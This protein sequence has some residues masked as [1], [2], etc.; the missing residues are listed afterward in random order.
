[1]LKILTLILCEPLYFKKLAT[2][3]SF[4][5]IYIK[6]SKI[7]IIYTRKF[8][9]FEPRSSLTREDMCVVNDLWMIQSPDWI[10]SKPRDEESF[11][12]R[13]VVSTKIVVTELREEVHR[14]NIHDETED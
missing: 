11:G 10:N 2:D 4:R 5:S 7:I 12:D 13:K 3:S 8:N 14:E 6:E 1:M 9:N